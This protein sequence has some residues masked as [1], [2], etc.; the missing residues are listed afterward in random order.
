[1]KKFKRTVFDRLFF[2]LLP[3]SVARIKYFRKHKVFAMLG[4]NVF[5]QSR[6][7]P[8]E[9]YLVKIHNNVTIAADVFI[10]PHDGIHMVFNNCPKISGGTEYIL[11]V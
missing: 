9:P 11:A 5:Y 6:R 4:E 10:I 3:N 8:V 1:M 7:I 2:Y